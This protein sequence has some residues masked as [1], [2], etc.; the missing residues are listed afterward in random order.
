MNTPFPLPDRFIQKLGPLP[1]CGYW[2]LDVLVAGKWDG[3]LVVD[4]TYRCIGAFAWNR[5]E[6]ENL[7]FSVDNIEDVRPACLWNLVLAKYTALICAVFPLATVLFVVPVLL[8]IATRASVWPSLVAVILSS[9]SLVAM[10]KAGWGRLCFSGVPLI[11][12][13][14][15]ECL[16]GAVNLVHGLI[17]LTR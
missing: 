1:N 14:S 5:V 4:T 11:V 13:A 10:V 6:P 12:L 8:W 2:K 7:P 15:G 9:S 17:S 16:A 3:I